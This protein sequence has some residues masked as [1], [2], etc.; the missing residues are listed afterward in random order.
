MPLE[1]VPVGT[2]CVNFG[3]SLGG[4]VFV[5]AAQA[6][7]QNGLAEGIRRGAPSLPSEAFINSGAS[8]VGQV[9]A[10]LGATPREVEV[11]RGAYLDGLRGAYFISVG[12]AGAA[13]AAACGLTW[14]K[15]QKRAPAPA[16]DEGAAEK[17]GE[18]EKQADGESTKAGTT[19]V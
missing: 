5:A 14:K 3:Q 13:F 4:A 7:F 2:A 17:A 9:L 11:V 6:V 19:R 12:C 1:W 10:R 16:G 18:P 8:E 15:I